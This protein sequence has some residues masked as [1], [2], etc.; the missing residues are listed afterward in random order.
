MRALLAWSVISAS[1]IAAETPRRVAQDGV[2]VENTKVR[3]ASASQPRFQSS[4]RPQGPVIPQMYRPAAAWAVV[5]ENLPPGVLIMMVTVSPDGQ[6]IE[7]QPLR[8]DDGLE[9][10]ESIQ[11]PTFETVGPLWTKGV[12]TLHLLV[13]MPDG[14]ES[15][16]S[17]DFTTGNY[18]R[19]ERERSELIPLVRSYR[20]V[21]ADGGLTLEITGRFTSDRPTVLLEDVIVPREAVT[22]VSNDL[23]RVNLNAVP[24]FRNADLADHLLT[25]AQGGWTDSLPIRY[26]P[27]E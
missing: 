23:I 11:L 2:P 20:F 8:Y 22:S 4:Q 26:V 3:K 19:N 17:A 13:T 6:E 1:L 25:V 9:A 14:S 27:A 7:H 18:Y 12:W 10:G 15:Q 21:R 16:T 5:T 24:N